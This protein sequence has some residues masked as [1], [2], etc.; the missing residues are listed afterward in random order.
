MSDRF[1]ACATGCVTALCLCLAAAPAVGGENGLIDFSGAAIVTGENPANL[2]TLAAQSCSGISN[3][4]VR[5]RRPS[6]RRRR[7]PGRTSCWAA[8]STTGR[9]PSLSTTVSSGRA[10]KSS[11]RKAS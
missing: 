5:R 4:S 9:S 8:R 6:S 10:R 7:R 3:T 1:F 2:E 11:A